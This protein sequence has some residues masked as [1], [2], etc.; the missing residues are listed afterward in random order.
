VT[1]GTGDLLRVANGGAGSSVGY[2]LLVIG[3]TT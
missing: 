1:A 3:S 2:R